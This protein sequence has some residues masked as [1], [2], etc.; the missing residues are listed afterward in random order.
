MNISHDLNFK[1][2]LPSKLFGFSFYQDS[3]RVSIGIDDFTK[4]VHRLVF[5]NGQIGDFGFWSLT[6][7]YLTFGFLALRQLAFW[8]LRLLAFGALG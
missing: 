2:H 3:K 7:G 5:Q 6:F 8:Y 4:L 1:E